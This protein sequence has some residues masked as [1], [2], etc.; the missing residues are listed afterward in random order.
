MKRI[1]KVRGLKKSKRGAVTQG[2][3]NRRSRRLPGQIGHLLALIC[4]ELLRLRIVPKIPILGASD[5]LCLALFLHTLLESDDSI[6]ASAML[7]LAAH[8]IRSPTL[9][10]KLAQLATK[11]QIQRGTDVIQFLNAT[12]TK[13]PFALQ[14]N[15]LPYFPGPASFHTGVPAVRE[16]LQVCHEMNFVAASAQL[17]KFSNGRTPVKT[18]MELLIALPGMGNYGYH[19]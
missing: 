3:I 19:P 14:K 1:K 13:S 2:P 12:L 11:K 7:F 5:V 4:D 6:E 9:I 15:G 17:V 10:A 8:H 18:T 16:W